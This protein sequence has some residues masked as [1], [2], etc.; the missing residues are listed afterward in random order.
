MQKLTAEAMHPVRTSEDPMIIWDNFKNDSWVEK[1]GQPD[2]HYA[3]QLS[4]AEQQ[5]MYTIAIDAYKGSYGIGMTKWWW[6]QLPKSK[7]NSGK[8]GRPPPDVV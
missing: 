4:H 2:L 6:G 3:V 5:C 7:G 1:D 8:V